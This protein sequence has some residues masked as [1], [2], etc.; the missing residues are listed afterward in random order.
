M[1]QLAGVLIL[2]FSIFGSSQE[3]TKNHIT[4]NF[5]YVIIYKNHLEKEVDLGYSYILTNSK[6]NSY[7]VII[8]PMSKDS[9][10]ALFFDHDKI[11]AYPNFSK[12]EFLTKDTL[13]VGLNWR[14]DYSYSPTHD[15]KCK[16][17]MKKDTLIN[18]KLYKHYASVPKK[19]KD[20][21]LG[22]AHYIIEPKTEFHLPI[23]VAKRHYKRRK[24]DFQLPKGIFKRF[25]FQLNNNVNSELDFELINYTKR[26]TFLILDRM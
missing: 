1:K 20:S 10:S 12:K 6:D 18:N 17:I 26:E 14:K 7:L 9:L 19:I 8:T 4:Y 21:L 25:Y 24:K 3:K 13:N 5:D 11:V 22:S 2:F 15:G 16:F 23:L